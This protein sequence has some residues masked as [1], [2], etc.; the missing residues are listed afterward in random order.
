MIVSHQP[1][2]DIVL[3]SRL[4][5]ESK[6][7]YLDSMLNNKWDSDEEIKIRTGNG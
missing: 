1:Y 2:N 3:Y 5:G 4:K 6:F 7:K